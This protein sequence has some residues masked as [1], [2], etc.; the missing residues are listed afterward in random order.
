MLREGV[1]VCLRSVHELNCNLGN[2]LKEAG[3][4]EGALKHYRA[5]CTLKIRTT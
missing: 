1:R 3:D 2:A 4:H 5:A